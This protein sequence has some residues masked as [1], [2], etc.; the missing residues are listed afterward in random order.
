[1]KKLIFAAF[2]LASS[3]FDYGAL[4]ADARFD[5]TVEP[6]SRAVAVGDVAADT[7]FV[8]LFGPL[9]L[10]TAVFA[11]GFLEHGWRVSEPDGGAQ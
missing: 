6:H 4:Y 9:A 8:S 10:P 2:W 11:T 3:V 7:A 1:M 5:S